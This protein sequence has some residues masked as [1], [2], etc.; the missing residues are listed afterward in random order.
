MD[1]WKQS[2]QLVT[3]AGIFKTGEEEEE[4]V[5][6]MILPADLFSHRPASSPNKDLC[7]HIVIEI[8]AA[9][10]AEFPVDAYFIPTVSTIH[11]NYFHTF[12][13]T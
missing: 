5:H 4:T 1:D 3:R 8:V 2:I 6:Q 9:K 13:P 10:P 12:T 11:R 7:P